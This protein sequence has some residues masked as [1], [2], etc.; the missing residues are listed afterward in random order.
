[1]RGTT[2]DE[3][4]AELQQQQQQRQQLVILT[5]LVLAYAWNYKR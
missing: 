2:S 1:M 3:H 5:W 4:G